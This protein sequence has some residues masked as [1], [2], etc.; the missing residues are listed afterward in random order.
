[1]FYRA[2]DGI[3]MSVSIEPGV[4]AVKARPPKPLFRLATPVYVPSLDGQSFL[5]N[6]VVE[7]ASPIT[8]LLNWDPTT[9]RRAEN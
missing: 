5:T 6:I 3:L 9:R 2:A 1:M 8:I 7:P 4:A